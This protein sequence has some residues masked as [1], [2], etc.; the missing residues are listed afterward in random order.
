MTAFG[1]IAA[2]KAEHKISTM[3]R[4][5][6]VSRSGFHA[7]QQREPRA[8]ALEDEWLTV[9]SVR[10]TVTTASVYG[11]TQDP[12]ELVSPRH[13]SAASALNG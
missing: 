7:W 2:K 10:S 5:L 3:C 6:D 8:R 11:V 13:R 12:A 9:A 4:V 1:F